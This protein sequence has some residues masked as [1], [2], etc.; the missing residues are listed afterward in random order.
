MKQYFVS[1]FP[2]LKLLKCQE[3]DKIC[4]MGDMKEDYDDYLFGLENDRCVNL[5]KN[6]VSRNN[7]SY[8]ITDAENAVQAI[9]YFYDTIMQ[10][11]N[12]IRRVK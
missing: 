10:K 7:R 6:L 1:Y 9:S 8:F 2:L 4:E 11:D 3:V 5:A 12:N